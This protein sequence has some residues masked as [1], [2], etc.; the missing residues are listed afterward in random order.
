MRIKPHFIPLFG[1]T[2]DPNSLDYM[3]VMEYAK[4][5]SLRNILKNIS[6]KWHTILNILKE[7]ISGLDA[8]HESK[9]I[10]I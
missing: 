5:G 2:Q 9:L 1:F 6:Y 10:F 3:I 8:I 7:I 4:N